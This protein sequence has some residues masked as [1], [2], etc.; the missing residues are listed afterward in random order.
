[1]KKLRLG[2]I[3]KENYIRVDT[4]FIFTTIKVNLDVNVRFLLKL[5]VLLF[6]IVGCIH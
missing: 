2:Y 6:S 1:M 3:K 4:E 5:H